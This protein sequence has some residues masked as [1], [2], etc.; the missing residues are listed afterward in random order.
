MRPITPRQADLLTFIRNYLATHD[1][2]PTVAEIAK[3]MGLAST[4]GV[5]DQLQSLERKGA[6]QLI[7]SVARGIRLL[8]A[9][10]DRG[11]PIVGRIAAGNPIL[12][13]QHIEGYHQIDARIF[14]PRAD[15][16][17]RVHGMS[18][19]DAGILDGDLLAVHQTPT[20]ERGQIVVV[21]LDDEAT[22]KRLRL[23]GHKAYLEPANLAFKPIVVDLR[24]TELAVE[25]IGVGVLRTF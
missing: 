7:P 13:S 12:A 9:D 19:K 4:N 1:M 23:R 21:R 24:R 25:G 20:A 15:Y 16:L 5:R 18:M 8:E 3:G 11:L 2:P 10:A 17:L 14:K 22:V 6:L